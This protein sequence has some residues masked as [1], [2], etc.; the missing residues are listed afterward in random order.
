MIVLIHDQL[1]ETLKV[2]WDT[3]LDRDQLGIFDR[4]LDALPGVEEIFTARYSAIVRI[5]P[6]ITTAEQFAEDLREALKPD[7]GAVNISVL[8]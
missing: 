6:H 8:R 4:I 7:F 3:R 1:D 5:A 2:R